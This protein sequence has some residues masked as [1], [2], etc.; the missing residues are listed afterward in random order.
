MEGRRNELAL[1]EQRLARVLDEAEGRLSRGLHGQAQHET[2]DTKTC[3][4]LDELRRHR[5]AL[6]Q[7]DL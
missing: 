6:V 4:L 7:A 2:M 3:K 1:L 5:A